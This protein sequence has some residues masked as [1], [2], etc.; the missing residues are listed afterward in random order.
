MAEQNC[1]KVLSLLL[2]DAQSTPHAG[3]ALI[4]AFDDAQREASRT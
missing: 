4:C 2:D 3:C 1:K